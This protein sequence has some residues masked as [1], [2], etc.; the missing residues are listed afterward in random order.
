MLIFLFVNYG[1]IKFS[2]IFIHSPWWVRQ[3]RSV[4][5]DFSSVTKTHYHGIL[6]FLLLGC[7]EGTSLERNVIWRVNVDHY[8]WF[9]M[10]VSFLSSYHYCCY[11]LSLYRNHYL[12]HPYFDEFLLSVFEVETLQICFQRCFSVFRLIC[13]DFIFLLCLLLLYFVFLLYFL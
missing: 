6:P 1:F 2:N 9:Q 7:S 12:S 4:P 5:F 8:Q 13:P 11:L 10:I 3:Y